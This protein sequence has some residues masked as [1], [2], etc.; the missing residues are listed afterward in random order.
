MT[1]NLLELERTGFAQFC[2]G[3]GEKPFRARQL[4]RWIHQFGADDFDAMTDISKALPKLQIRWPTIDKRLSIAVVGTG[5]SRLEVIVGED[6]PLRLLATE[7]ELTM[8]QRLLPEPLHILGG[9]IV[10]ADATLNPARE[11][12]VLLVRG[13]R[14]FADGWSFGAL[15]GEVA[16]R[17]L[18]AAGI[19]VQADLY[20]GTM[21]SERTSIG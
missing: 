7:L 16:A 18:P 21:I 5:Q 2:A 17:V 1:V 11:E 8:V 10:S 19:D 9:N 12:V 13:A 14:I 3:L 4:M 15:D 20:N 6:Q